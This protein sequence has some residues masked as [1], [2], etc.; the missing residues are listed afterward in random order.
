MSYGVRV[1][2]TALDGA[3]HAVASCDTTVA[4]E[5]DRALARGQ[6]LIGRVELP[7]PPGTWEWR[8]ALSQGADAGVVLPRDSVRVGAPGPAL[9]LSDLALGI[10]AASARWFPTPA[11]TVLLTP[12]NLFLKGSEVELYYEAG[13]ARAGTSYRHEIAVFHVRDD[14]RVDARSRGHAPGRRERQRPRS[15]ARTAHCGSTG[16]SRAGTSWRSRW[17][18]RRAPPTRGGGR[19]AWSNGSD[20]MQHRDWRDAP[21]GIGGREPGLRP[22]VSRSGRNWWHLRAVRQ[23]AAGVA[24]WH[25]R[26]TYSARRLADDLAPARRAAAIAVWAS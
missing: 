24:R 4:F 7:L 16:S 25:R 8:A 21:R 13:G 3:G 18:G 10:R 26:P 9:A 11:D 1:R 23:R 6:Y 12:F 5:L 2:L 15:S 17:A 19:F 22:A 20:S 14:D